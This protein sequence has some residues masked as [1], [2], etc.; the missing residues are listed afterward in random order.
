M[1]TDAGNNRSFNSCPGLIA[2]QADR[3]KLLSGRALVIGCGD[4][5]GIETLSGPSFDLNVFG[6]GQDLGD[7]ESAKTRL[8][9]IG[10]MQQRL[11]FVADHTLPY[12]DDFFSLVVLDATLANKNP[13]A[14]TFQE[15]ER[16]MRPGGLM[17]AGVSLPIGRKGSAADELSLDDWLDISSADRIEFDRHDGRLLLWRQLRVVETQPEQGWAAGAA[18]QAEIADGTSVVA[19]HPMESK[20]LYQKIYDE[21]PWYGNADEGRC[22]GVRLLEE[23]RDWLVGPVIDLGCGRGQMVELLRAEGVQ[24]E[25][26]DQIVVNPEMRVGDISAPIED[27]AS[28]QSAVCV[29]CIEHLYEDQVIGLFKNMQ[30]TKRQAFSIHNGEST[31]TGQELHVNRKDFFDWTKLIREYFDIASAIQIHENQMLYLTL[32]K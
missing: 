1:K 29:D 18:S 17:L 15:I 28:F 3:L 31:G 2:S 13:C 24:A 4:G 10:G 22:P 25:G 11:S 26:I 8:S 30:Q 16:V 20:Q 32:S 21:N 27:I 5:S 9:Y 12:E 7:I 6:V 19:G 14:E 23:F